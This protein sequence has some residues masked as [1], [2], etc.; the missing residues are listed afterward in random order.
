MPSEQV[1]QQMVPASALES[2]SVGGVNT[3]VIDRSVAGLVQ[4]VAIPASPTGEFTGK[5]SV[6]NLGPVGLN[7]VPAVIGMAMTNLAMSNSIVP[8][9]ATPTL[10]F[11]P[12][13]AGPVAFNL[14]ASGIDSFCHA[15][16]RLAQVNQG[17]VIHAIN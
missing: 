8:A 14:R 9:R 13:Q 11:A 3:T 12:N 2:P 7:Q 16:D 6:L 1:L 10:R 15:Q 5:Q 17:A 4:S